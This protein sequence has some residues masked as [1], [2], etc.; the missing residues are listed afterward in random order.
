MLIYKKEIKL[1]SIE[2][3]YN[4][5]EEQIKISLVYRNGETR[6]VCILTQIDEVDFIEFRQDLVDV[7]LKAKEYDSIKK[8]NK[9]LKQK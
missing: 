3:Q 6:S 4:L 9:A 8:S 7:A 1:G 2:F 5:K